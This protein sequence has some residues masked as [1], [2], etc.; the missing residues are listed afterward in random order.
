[1]IAINKKRFFES[2]V[3][4]LLR[5][6]TALYLQ[7]SPD[8]RAA[9][10]RP[11]WAEYRQEIFRKWRAAGASR[12][13]AKTL[14]NNEAYMLQHVSEG[15]DEHFLEGLRMIEATFTPDASE[16]QIVPIH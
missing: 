11:T 5:E 8:E 4:R 6:T 15:R 1:M 2:T 7:L 13:D 14:A 9:P 10:L 16:M 3:D 12:H